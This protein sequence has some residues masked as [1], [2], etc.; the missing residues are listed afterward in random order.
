M[1][2]RPEC[3]GYGRTWCAARD[4]RVATIAIGYGDGYPRHAAMGTPVWIGDRVVPL[5]GRVSMD[6]LTVDLT[7]HP[8]AEVGD[9]VELWGG[10]VSVDEVAKAAGTISYELLTGIT[11]RVPRRYL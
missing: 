9:A 5:V 7:Y 10:N 1:I 3:V 8:D 11:S 2:L 4:T 6:M